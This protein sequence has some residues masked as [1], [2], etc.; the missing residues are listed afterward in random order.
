MPALVERRDDRQAERLAELEVL[1][2]AARRDVDDAG[3]LV[4]A[5]LGPRRRPG[6]RTASG[7][8]ASCPRRTPSAPR[9]GR[10]TA[11]R[12]ASRRGPRRAPPRGPRTARERGLERALAEPELVARPGGRGRSAAPA[13]RRPRRSR[14]AST[15]VVVQTRSASPGPV[16]EREPDRQPRILA[17][18]VAL[19]HLHLRD[20]RP[21]A[22]RTTASCRGPCR[23]SR[24]GGTRRGSPR[25]GRCSRC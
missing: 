12:S 7:V 8:V 17:V 4:L 16:D 22:R 3:P 6:A 2:A 14:S 5:D 21:A 10:R 18:L 11:R 24:A 9:A 15:G 25:S 1:G 20:A 23:S 19:V 13:R